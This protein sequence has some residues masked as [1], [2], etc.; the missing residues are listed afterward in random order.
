[1]SQTRMASSAEAVANARKARLVWGPM[2]AFR[3]QTPMRAR[4]IRAPMPA[5]RI[6]APMPAFRM[7]AVRSVHRIRVQRSARR[8]WNLMSVSRNRAATPA[9]STGVQPRAHDT[10]RHSSAAVACPVRAASP[11]PRASASTLASRN[12]GNRATDRMKRA[13]M[14][15]AE[16]SRAERADKPARRDVQ[17]RGNA[18]ARRPEQRARMEAA[19]SVRD[20]GGFTV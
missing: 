20:E 1:M 11:A 3:I 19:L 9:A 12:P 16:M 8:M 2:A 10:P 6:R 7:R 13:E 17:S 15:R 5:R 4:R 18:R 14:S